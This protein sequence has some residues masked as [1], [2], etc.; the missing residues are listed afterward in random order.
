MRVLRFRKRGLFESLFKEKKVG[1]A[2]EEE[3]TV[4]EPQNIRGKW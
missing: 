2:D 1:T 4:R 3:G